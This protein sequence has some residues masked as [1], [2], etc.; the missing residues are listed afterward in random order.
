MEKLKVGD[1]VETCQMLPGFVTEID[2]NQDGVS[3]FIPGVH[4]HW[5]GGH[6]S[7]THCGVHKVDSKYAMM[8]F[9]IGDERLKTIYSDGAKTG[10]SWEEIVEQE[11]NEIVTENKHPKLL[12]LFELIE[13][14]IKDSGYCTRENDK[15]Y[16]V[17][18]LER[19]IEKYKA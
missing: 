6:H 9:T 13:E 8:L 1:L 16:V 3:V 10:L 7:I 15:P 17:S 12:S 11:Y 14:T 5:A 18:T 19:L 2:D 4:K